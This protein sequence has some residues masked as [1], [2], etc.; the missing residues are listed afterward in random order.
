MERAQRLVNNRVA[1]RR[2]DVDRV[3]KRARLRGPIRQHDFLRPAVG[4]RGHLDAGL[5]CGA[6]VGLFFLAEHDGELLPGKTRGAELEAEVDQVV[7][8]DDILHVQI[9]EFQIAGRPIAA[10]ADQQ[11]RYALAAGVGGCIQQSRAFGVDAVGGQDERRGR[12][13]AQL[14]QRAANGGAQGG[15]VALGLGGLQLC[16]NTRHV[17]ALAFFHLAEVKESQ[18][19]ALGQVVEQLAV[20]LDKQRA[21]DVPAGKPLGFFRARP[22]LATAGPLPPAPFSCGCSTIPACA[23]RSSNALRAASSYWSAYSCSACRR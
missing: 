7:D 15:P 18:L 17:T 9:A 22:P 13:A 19:V 2:L 23:I 5:L 11:Q 6:A 14:V 20:V 10:Q 4:A 12:R 21:G 3:A 1:G 8:E 16:D